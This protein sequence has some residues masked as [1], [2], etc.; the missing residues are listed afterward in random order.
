MQGCI[1]QNAM[2]EYPVLILVESRIAYRISG[3][4]LSPIRYAE[5]TESLGHCNEYVGR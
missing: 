1:V 2:P 3:M 4:K 5:L